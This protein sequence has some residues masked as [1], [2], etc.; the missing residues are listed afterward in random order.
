MP[1]KPCFVTIPEIN[2]NEKL[3][4]MKPELLVKDQSDWDA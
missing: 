1:K 4:L 3:F 2:K